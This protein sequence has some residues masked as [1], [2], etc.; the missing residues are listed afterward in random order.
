LVQEWVAT[1]AVGMA[2]VLAV[3]LAQTSVAL[4]VEEKEQMMAR[5]RVREWALQSATAKAAKKGRGWA[6]EWVQM[7]AMEL[8][9]AS[10]VRL[11]G[12]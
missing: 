7:S 2:K 8:E 5:A 9:S 11:A 3:Q 4:S 1:L 12:L 6:V 10:G